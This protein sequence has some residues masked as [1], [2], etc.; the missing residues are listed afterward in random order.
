MYFV[1][2]LLSLI[3]FRNDLGVFNFL[4]FIALIASFRRTR[5]S[6]QIFYVFFGLTVLSQ[7]GA[8][9]LHAQFSYGMEAFAPHAGSAGMF[10]IKFLIGCLIMV[11]G[12]FLSLRAPTARLERILSMY[13]IF[14]GAWVVLPS[15]YFFAVGAPGTNLDALGHTFGLLLGKVV[16][17]G[18]LCFRGL[19]IRRQVELQ[20]IGK[21]IAF[22]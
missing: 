13:F 10:W 6:V 7:V 9:F 16:I 8:S 22:L 18:L 11:A 3:L 21:S 14:L 17:Y 19:E 4:A 1:T 12:F 2:V 5:R 15:C 20:R